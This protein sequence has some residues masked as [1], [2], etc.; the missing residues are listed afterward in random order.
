MADKVCVT[1]RHCMV[2]WR[3]LHLNVPHRFRRRISC[4]ESR[5][6]GPQVSVNPSRDCD[7]SSACGRQIKVTRGIASMIQWNGSTQYQEKRNDVDTRHRGAAL[8]IN[9]NWIWILI[10]IIDII[11]QKMSLLYSKDHAGIYVRP[12]V[13]IGTG[14]RSGNPDTNFTFQWPWLP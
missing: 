4:W 6:L 2:R 7:R 14:R 12:D 11:A 10:S 9:R 1:F 13:S 5:V 3:L 8:G